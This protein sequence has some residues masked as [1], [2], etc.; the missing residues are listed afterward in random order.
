MKLNKYKQW[1]LV[2]LCSP[3]LVFADV[4]LKLEEACIGDIELSD[5][6]ISIIQNG[7]TTSSSMTAAEIAQVKMLLADDGVSE[8]DVQGQ[9]KAIIQA[10]SQGIIFQERHAGILGSQIYLEKKE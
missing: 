7:G 5:A 10:C 8:L 1:L 3:M 6:V 2:T 4:S 9:F